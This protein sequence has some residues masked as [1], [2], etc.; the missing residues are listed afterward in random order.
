MDLPTL[1]FMIVAYL[2]AGF[3][4]LEG[5]DYGVG[6]LLPF[7]S[8]DDGDRRMVLTSIGGVWDGNEVWMVSAGAVLFAS[9]PAWY[10]TLFS[11]LYGIFIVIL[12]GLILRGIGLK[13]RNQRQDRLWCGTW[14]RLIAKGSFIAA[15]FWG[16]VV[17]DLLTGLPINGQMVFTGGIRDMITP[18]SLLTAVAVVLLFLLHGASYLSIKVSGD[19]LEKVKKIFPFVFFPALLT[20]A[21]FLAA[22]FFG[23]GMLRS[24][25]ELILAGLAVVTL[26]VCGIVFKRSP[27]ASFWS[28]GATIVLVGGLVFAH[29]Y[30][31]VLI[32]TLNPAWSLTVHNASSS[33]CSLRIMSVVALFFIPTTL[34]YQGW[35]YWILRK[36]LDKSDL[37]Y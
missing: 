22:G 36:R 16:I 9:F 14:D 31:R 6:M 17:G 8:K 4:F 35:T 15:F 25:L 13:F 19:L 32:S 26:L 37:S 2:F 1:W 21:A 28:S 34:L 27:L 24:A 33:A 5:F 12:C 30:P 10:A 7:L 23:V 20:A 29:L 3:F 11:S 18:F